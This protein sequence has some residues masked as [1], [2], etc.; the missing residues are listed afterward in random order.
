MIKSRV[1]GKLIN[2][3]VPNQRKFGIFITL[4]MF[5]T[6]FL[7]LRN[8]NTH[9][10]LSVERDLG[11]HVL[12]IK[13]NNKEPNPVTGYDA[14]P[15]RSYSTRTVEHRKTKLYDFHVQLKGKMVPYGGYWL[16]V[17]NESSF[18]TE[19]TPFLNTHSVKC[20]H[21]GVELPFRKQ[22]KI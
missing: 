18:C 6:F 13:N 20:L 17:I 1:K 11:S 2:L 10:A 15:T 8:F 12:P 19:N 14:G 21:L 4:I 9:R 3:A 5:T 22:G 7:D 16:P